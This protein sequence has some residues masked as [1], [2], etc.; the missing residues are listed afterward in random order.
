MHICHLCERKGQLMGLAGGPLFCEGC[1]LSVLRE[2][3]ERGLINSVV[4]SVR[5]KRAA[6]AAQ[7]KDSKN[8]STP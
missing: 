6:Y 2:V 1:M 7:A 8:R 5:A 4:A 3:V